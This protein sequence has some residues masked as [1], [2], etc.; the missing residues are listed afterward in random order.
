MSIGEWGMVVWL[1]STVSFMSYNVPSYLWIFSIASD[2]NLICKFCKRLGMDKIW[3]KLNCL[4]IP[5]SWYPCLF[6]ITWLNSFHLNASYSA[7]MTPDHL[8][9]TV[10]NTALSIYQTGKLLKRVEFDPPSEQ[11]SKTMIAFVTIFDSLRLSFIFSCLFDKMEGQT[12]LSVLPWTNSHVKSWIIT[13]YNIIT[14]NKGTGTPIDYLYNSRR[15]LSIGQQVL[16]YMHTRVSLW[17]LG[18]KTSVLK[19]KGWALYVP[20]WFCPYSWPMKLTLTH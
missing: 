7:K 9:N 1:T 14:L 11:T 12:P 10:V 15:S 8:L 16:Y 13:E 4:V 6:A 20:L 3:I 5:M 2:R 19:S 17:S 18:R